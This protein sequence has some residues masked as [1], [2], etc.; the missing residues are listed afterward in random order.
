MKIEMRLF[1]TLRENRQKVISME[2]P[3]G[4]DAATLIKTLNIPP[5]EIAILLVNGRNAKSNHIL[6]EGDTVSLFPPIGGG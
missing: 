4:T 5:N 2:V 6:Q 3:E 1:A